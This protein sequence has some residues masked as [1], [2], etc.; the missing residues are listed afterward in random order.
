MEYRKGEEVVGA[1]ALSRIYTEANSPTQENDKVNMETHIEIIHRGSYSL[2]YKL[3]KYH[4]WPNMKKY[5]TRV[6][7]RCETC[8][9]NNRKNNGGELFI[10]TRC[11]LKIKN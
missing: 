9:I 3:A 7:K 1:D 8:N 2:E 6:L 10:E 5:N 11:P 4:H